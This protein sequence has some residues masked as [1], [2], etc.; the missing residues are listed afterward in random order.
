VWFESL[1]TNGFQYQVSKRLTVR[2]EQLRRRATA[3]FSQL[4][5]WQGGD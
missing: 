5:P 4:P 1:T 3:I 2:P